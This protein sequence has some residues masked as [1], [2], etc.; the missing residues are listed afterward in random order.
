MKLI[1]SLINSFKFFQNGY[2]KPLFLVK[3]ALIFYNLN[4]NNEKNLNDNFWQTNYMR[5][6][7]FQN[8]YF[9]T[10]QTQYNTIRYKPDDSKGLL[11]IS[12]NNFYKKLII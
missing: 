12:I 2:R 3:S 10:K 7:V 4:D 9:K 11:E 1:K 6:F 8:N 5:L